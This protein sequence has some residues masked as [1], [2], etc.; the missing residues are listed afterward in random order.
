L[1]QCE[2]PFSPLQRRQLA[3]ADVAQSFDLF[4]QVDVD[5]HVTAF[6]SDLIGNLLDHSP[7]KFRHRGEAFLRGGSPGQLSLRHLV[8]SLGHAAFAAHRSHHLALELVKDLLGNL[9]IA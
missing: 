1:K 9:S 8:G 3:L 5:F 7:H 2:G 4:K 6:A